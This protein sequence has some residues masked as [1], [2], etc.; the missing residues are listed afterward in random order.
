MQPVQITKVG[1]AQ[2]AY[3]TQPDTQF[4]PNG[5]YRVKLQLTKE[6]GQDIIKAVNDVIAKKIAE[7]VKTTPGNQVKRAPLPYK[8]LDD[9]N[10]EFSFKCNASGINAKTRQPFTQKPELK[11][12]FDKPFPEGK[13]IWSGSKIKVAYS[14]FGYNQP[15]IGVGCT[16]RLKAVQVI[17]L[18]EGS[19]VSFGSVEKSDYEVNGLPDDP[20]PDFE[21][22]KIGG[23]Q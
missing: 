5:T 19:G 21:K 18:V 7:A 2:Y 9:G 15:G 22:D 8:F 11:D 14:A 20:L 10:V 3:L 12:K 13:Q 23:T 17:E 6:D 16:L 1:E 4:N